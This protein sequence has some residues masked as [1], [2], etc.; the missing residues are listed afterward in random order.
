MTTPPDRPALGQTAV[1]EITLRASTTFIDVSTADVLATAAA[2]E[3]LA[4]EGE[5]RCALGCG[6]LREHLALASCLCSRAA[7]ARP[8]ITLAST[9]SWRR[10]TR[11]GDIRFR[12][13]LRRGPIGRGTIV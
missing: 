13:G 1:D 9:L 7:E 6:D 5:L 3:H 2:D 11:G 8:T 10:T 12:T 4:V